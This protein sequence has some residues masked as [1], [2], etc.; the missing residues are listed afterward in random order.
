MLKAEPEGRSGLTCCQLQEGPGQEPGRR[1]RLL[2]FSGGRDVDRL[3]TLPTLGL[4]EGYAGTLIEG[5]EPA[6]L[7]AGE[8][9]EEIL[10][11]IIRRDEAVALLVAEPLDR[12]FLGH[13]LAPTFLLWAKPQSAA[14]R[15]RAAPHRFD[16]TYKLR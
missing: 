15:F 14:S 8:V 11:P 12:S 10:A 13:A 1:V 5:L 2:L 16:P 7:Y 6:A 4:L 9:D 3:H